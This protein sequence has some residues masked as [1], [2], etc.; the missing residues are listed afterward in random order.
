MTPNTPILK[1]GHWSRAVAELD[2]AGR[3]YVLV[4]IIGARGSTPRDQGSK[5]VVSADDQGDLQ[6]IGS[7]GGGHLEYLVIARA[8]ELLSQGRASQQL[9]DFPLGAKLGQCCGGSAS[10]LLES[11]VPRPVNLMLFG[12]GH[13]G[14][15]LIKVLAELPCRVWWVD[16]RESLL[17]QDVEMAALPDNVTAVCDTDAVDAVARMP[18]NSYYLVMTHNHQLDYDL[19]RTILQRDDARYIGLIGS[20]TKWQRFKLRFDHRGIDAQQYQ[21]I[22][23]PV[24]LS[25]VSGKLPME[26]AVSI[27]AEIIHTYQQ[28]QAKQPRPTRRG[29]AWPEV[30]AALNRDAS[31]SPDIR[32]EPHEQP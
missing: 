5:M 15:A 29:V 22:H 32:E 9:E 12:A 17:Q 23:C 16:E 25:A 31:P 18:G 7:I 11:F 14:R 28:Q 27:A 4:T 24:G 26:V 30:Q 3:A 8:G 1:S 6:C 2:A 20:A 21:H 19:C 10:V 13:V